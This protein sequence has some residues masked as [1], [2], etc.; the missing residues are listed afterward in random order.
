MKKNILQLLKISALLVAATALAPVRGQTPAAASPA[1][2]QA[3]VPP[4]AAPPTPSL[5]PNGTMDKD[6]DGDKWPDG[7]PQAKAGSTWELEEGVHFIRLQAQAPD[8]MTM[9]YRE[10]PI[11]A[12]VKAVQLKFRGRV[13]NLSLGSNVWFDARI[14]ADF[15]NASREKVPGKFPAPSFRKDTGAWVEKSVSFVIPEGAT[16]IALMPALFKVKSGTFDLTDITLTAV[17]PA[18]ILA[19]DEAAATARAVDIARKLVAR[20]AKAAQI[21][22]ER[23]NLMP[24]GDME[25][26]GGK[27]LVEEEGNHFVRLQSVEPGKMVMDYR[28]ADLPEG[29]KALELTWRQRITGLKKGVQPWFDAR[30]IMEWKDAAGVK[31]KETPP[32]AY[33]QKDTAG[34]VEKSTTFLVPEGAA[35]LVL[36]P[37][38]F[39]VNAGTFDLDNFVLKPVDPAPILA[40]KE[41]SD[42]RRAAAFVPDEEPNKAKWPKMLKV[43]GNR[44]HDPEGKEVWLQGMNIAS[45]EWSVQ[46]EQIA[47]SVVVATEQ[48]K[49]NVLRLP[50]KHDYWFGRKGQT[51]GGK[52]YREVVDKAILLAANRGAYVV[53][54]LHCYR[55]P[56]K[57]YLEFWTDAATRYKDHPAVL[58]DLMNEPHGVSWEVWRDGGFVEEKKKEGDEDAFLTEDEKKH[59]KHGF[60]SPG[61]QAM[62]NTVRATGAKN[63]VVAGGLDYAYELDGIVKGFGL[64]DPTG[65]GIMYSCH[66]YPWKKGWQKYLLDAAALHPILLGEVG[67]DVNK[68]NFMP[69]EQ[70]EDAETWVP[71]ILGLIQKY[72]LNWTGWCFHPGASPRMLLDWDY[73][74]TPVWGAPAKDALSGKQ[75]ELKKLR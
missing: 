6:V 64:K 58:F 5:I 32:P 73:T 52:S 46:G 23:G 43:S 30:I 34:W 17:D 3:T 48:W 55:A 26:G 25:T 36:M 14:L 2:A 44:L 20:Q 4:V 67:G 71:D 57:E 41:E 37:S 24:G 18:P 29:V 59:N 66:I 72:K 42:R 47:R 49:G 12:Q 22:Q 7:W 19:A 61:M 1:P 50:V 74:P 75:F 60:E 39:Q 40:K 35:T 33:S 51:D 56:R 13:S 53:L 63:I 21:L 31:M 10:V 45:L 16:M 65:N 62:L 28:T 70:Q 69:L 54:D 68:M 8:Q 27:N 15:L 9:L 11:P 38:L